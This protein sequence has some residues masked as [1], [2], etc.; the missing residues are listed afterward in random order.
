[1]QRIEY[2]AHSIGVSNPSTFPRSF[3]NLQMN[4]YTKRDSHRSEGCVA[5]DGGHTCPFLS[6]TDAPWTDFMLRPEVVA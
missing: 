6:G 5:L 4:A 1:M 2:C 3:V